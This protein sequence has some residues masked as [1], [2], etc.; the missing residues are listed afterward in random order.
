MDLD[1]STSSTDPLAKS[2]RK[3]DLALFVRKA[4]LESTGLL[5]NLPCIARP[6]IKYFLVAMSTLNSQTCES[7]DVVCRCIS[8][9]FLS[10][11]CDY[12]SVR[13]CADS[14]LYITVPRTCLP[15][16]VIFRSSQLADLDG[17]P[18]PD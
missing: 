6:R 15:N 8:S 17:S 12:P 5:I 14:M 10:H 4:C 1:L 9:V 2:H 11:A 13:I 7:G 3:G 18:I 16:L